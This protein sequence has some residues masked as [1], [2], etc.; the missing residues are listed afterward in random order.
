MTDTHAFDTLAVLLPSWRSSG[1]VGTRH[2]GHRPGGR[3][4]VN[5]GAPSVISAG[6]TDLAAAE[7]LDTA[8]GP[9][10]AGRSGLVAGAEQL[11][12]R[13]R[14]ATQFERAATG[15]RFAAPVQVDIA[16]CIRPRSCD[17]L[18]ASNLNPFP[19]TARFAAPVVNPRH[20]WMTEFDADG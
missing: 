9:L 14:I 15:A 2:R 17:A 3:K 16:C 18:T 11:D 1:T 13:V 10:S 6:C 20:G 4:A 12:P 7:Q 8:R 5:P 19:G